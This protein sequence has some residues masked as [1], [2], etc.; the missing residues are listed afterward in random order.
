[1]EKELTSKN[2]IKKYAIFA[3]LLLFLCAAIVL[4]F[5]PYFHYHK[6]LPF[7]KAVLWEKEYQVPGSIDHLDYDA[8]IVGSSEAENYNNNWFNENFD[9]RPV[10]AIRSYGG[11]ADLCYFLSRAFDNQEL[12]YVFYNLDV[13]TLAEDTS[14]TF[15]Q[16]GAPLYMYDSNP[17]NDVEYLLN[18]DILLERVPYSVATSLIGDYDE[19][20]SY[21]WWQWK[22]F[23]EDFAISNYYEHNDFKEAKAADTGHD[24][25]LAN[26]ELFTDIIEAHPD[27]EFYFFLPPYSILYWDNI[28]RSGE[29]EMYL[30]NEELV[31]K[32]LLKYDN[33]RIFNFQTEEDIVFN[34]DNYMDALHFTKDINHYIC[35]CLKDGTNELK[36]EED[37][38]S[39]VEKVR[40]YALEASDYVAKT[41]GDRIIKETE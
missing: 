28:Y 12:K 13:P 27:T 20:E 41:Y 10:K 24:A 21:N 31:M 3:V 9:C 5:D 6:P 4:I 30:Y 7:L 25:V 36:T 35:N 34:L 38:S 39:S 8:I 19:G 23:G 40:I 26:I 32:S 1:M 33:V 11:V 17:F 29:T 37:I 18:K 15:V 22:S 2:F 14:T 16:T